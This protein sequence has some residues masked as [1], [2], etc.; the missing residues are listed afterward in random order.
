MG[1]ECECVCQCVLGGR[2]GAC[3]LEARQGTFK[4]SMLAFCYK[5]FKCK[6][7]FNV[8]FM[9][10][11]CCCYLLFNLKKILLSL[12]VAIKDLKMLIYKSK[13]MQSM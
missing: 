4:K 11:D 6:V 2:G 12:N 13:T 5:L 9:F 8:F 1:K 3:M 7:K 10:V